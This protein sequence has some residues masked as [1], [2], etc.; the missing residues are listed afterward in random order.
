M[1]VALLLTL[2]LL[3][4]HGLSL[5]ISTTDGN[6]ADAIDTLQ[7]L[8][9]Q[10][11][12]DRDPGRLGIFGLPIPNPLSSLLQPQSTLSNAVPFL[13]TPPTVI[14]QST[15]DEGALGGLVSILNTILNQPTAVHQTTADGGAVG[16]L[17]SILNTILN[18]PTG[19][20]G[21]TLPTLTLGSDQPTDLVPLAP[22]VPSTPELTGF[23]RSFAISESG[24]TATFVLTTA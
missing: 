1:A 3:P 9:Q 20:V 23:I 2:L 21:G 12:A 10:V 18:E 11:E 24:D 16:G 7:H 15:A 6:T 13:P 8:S 5:A 14:A 4:H 19:I 22:L 17:L